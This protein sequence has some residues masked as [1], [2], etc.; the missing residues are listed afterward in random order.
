M[1]N[2]NHITDRD[3]EGLEMPIETVKIRVT[4][5]SHGPRI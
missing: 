1:G 3:Q 2:L 4:I 5:T